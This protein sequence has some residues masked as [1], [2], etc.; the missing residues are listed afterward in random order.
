MASKILAVSLDN[1]FRSP[2]HILSAYKGR[3]EELLQTAEDL[4]FVQATHG[5][6]LA[7][8]LL[9]TPLALCNIFNTVQSKDREQL[10]PLALGCTLVGALI[11]RTAAKALGSIHTRIGHVV[12]EWETK[13]TP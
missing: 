8:V 9:M 12:D 10:E 13:P 11:F 5:G 1:H 7:T 4:D 3:E 2:C 6:C